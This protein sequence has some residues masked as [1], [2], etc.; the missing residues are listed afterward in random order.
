[1][2]EN[3]YKKSEKHEPQQTVLIVDTSPLS[4]RMFNSLFNSLFGKTKD[5]NCVDDTR[6]LSGENDQTRTSEDFE[7]N[8]TAILLD[9]DKEW[10]LVEKETIEDSNSIEK[11]PRN[12]QLVPFKNILSHLGSISEHDENNFLS[13]NLPTLYPSSLDDSWFLT[14]P[15]CF[16]SVSSIQLESSPLENLL[17]EHP[18]MSVYYNFH[19]RASAALKNGETI[20]DLVVIEL[21]QNDV[22][23]EPTDKVKVHR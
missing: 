5:S 15:E 1:L 12:L 21:P 16:S 17:I 8:V 22:E 11:T 9:D 23:E 3:I 2:S 7:G 19:R 13:A 14:P 6:D 20:E 18:S 10:L 4:C